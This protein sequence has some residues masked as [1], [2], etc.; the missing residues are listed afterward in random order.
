MT[1]ILG[2][3]NVE[4]STQ[5]SELTND[6]PSDPVKVI[7]Q[8]NPSDGGYIVCDDNEQKGSN[9]SATDRFVQYASKDSATYI[10]GRKLNCQ[11]ME[12]DNFNFSAWSGLVSSSNNPIIFRVLGD[13]TLT[14]NL[15]VSSLPGVAFMGLI[16]S[17]IM[18]I[19]IFF[20]APLITI[21]REKHQLTMYRKEINAICEKSKNNK[22]A[23]LQHLEEKTQETRELFKKGRMNPR[24]YEIIMSTILQ[25]I[26]KIKRSN[27]EGEEPLKSLATT[28]CELVIIYNDISH[29]LI[30]DITNV[31]VKTAQNTSKDIY[32]KRLLKDPVI[33]LRRTIS[34]ISGTRP[35]PFKRHAYYSPGRGGYLA[36]LLFRRRVNIIFNNINS[37]CHLYLRYEKDPQK[38]SV[39]QDIISKVINSQQVLM[40]SKKEESSKKIDLVLRIIPIIFTIIAPTILITLINQLASSLSNVPIEFIIPYLTIPI[41]FI[42]FIAVVLISRYFTLVLWWYN[43]IIRISGVEEKEMRVYDYLLPIQRSGIKNAF[44]TFDESLDEKV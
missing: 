13:G 1:I 31:L 32:L 9:E 41:Y 20:L 40:G 34:F 4:A 36:I 21:L 12:N 10:F 5:D 44:Y 25:S 18:S 11:V 28:I 23:C 30:C 29:L 35:L 27:I 22:E 26:E 39:I 24:R 42:Y 8:I 19:L 38:I 2:H 3:A 14:A 43:N 17:F 6:T 15:K 37:T 33:H 16:I 7:F